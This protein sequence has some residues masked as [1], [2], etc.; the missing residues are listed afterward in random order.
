MEE[1][2][3][4]PNDQLGRSLIP[5]EPKGVN[6]AYFNGQTWILRRLL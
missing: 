3:E 2:S 6:A 5:Q 4:A 1:Q